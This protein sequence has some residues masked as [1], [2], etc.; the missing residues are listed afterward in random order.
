M[1]N[2]QIAFVIRNNSCLKNN[3]E[4]S[5]FNRGILIVLDLKVTNLLNS[6][7]HHYYYYHQLDQIL[8]KNQVILINHYTL[9]TI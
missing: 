2:N 7:N 8:F 5:L 9:R 4:I 1:E 3:K 6:D